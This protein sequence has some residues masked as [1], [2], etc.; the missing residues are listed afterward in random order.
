[1]T[2]ESVGHKKLTMPQC[3]TPC[4]RAR[5]SKSLRFPQTPLI[6]KLPFPDSPSPSDLDGGRSC[7]LRKKVHSSSSCSPTSRSTPSSE[8]LDQVADLRTGG[9]RGGVHVQTL[10]TR[11]PNN[12]QANGNNVNFNGNNTEGLYAKVIC[13]C[14]TKVINRPEGSVDH[15]IRNTSDPDSP[16][17]VAD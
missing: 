16:T 4:V 15:S 5:R 8:A 13:R 10:P 17:S 6:S 12:R 14:N 7:G 11:S 2:F 9:G 3:S 1:M